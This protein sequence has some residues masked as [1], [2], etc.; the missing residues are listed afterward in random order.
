MT[1]D[2]VKFIGFNRIKSFA[3]FKMVGGCQGS[4]FYYPELATK[5]FLQNEKVLFLVKVIAFLNLENTGNYS[6]CANLNRN[7]PKINFKIYYPL[8]FLS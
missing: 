7:F 1:E 5:N 3:G 4:L 2:A 6:T 8:H